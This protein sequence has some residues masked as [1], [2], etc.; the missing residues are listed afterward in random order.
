MAVEQRLRV[1]DRGDV[2]GGEHLLLCDGGLRLEF[3]FLL[4]V[5]QPPGNLDQR[6]RVQDAHHL[7]DPA[8][9]SACCL[10]NLALF[11]QRLGQRAL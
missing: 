11:V 6:V 7:A 8:S 2:Q 5:P 4:D 3:G 1:V 9:M 10:L